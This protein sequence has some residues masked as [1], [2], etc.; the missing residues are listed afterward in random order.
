MR[1][2]TAAP[3]TPPPTPA[4]TT[5]PDEGGGEFV[6]DCDEVGEAEVSVWCEVEVEVS[7]AAFGQ[8]ECSCSADGCSMYNARDDDDCALLLLV[9]DT[10]VTSVELVLDDEDVCPMPDHD[11]LPMTVT[12]V[13]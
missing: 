4:A 8:Q 2:K 3:P 10:L 1:P 11:V 5:E 6:G 7:L 9:L 12:I 13:G